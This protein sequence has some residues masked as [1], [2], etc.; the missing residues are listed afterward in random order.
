MAETAP[1][2]AIRN[3]LQR[4]AARLKALASLRDAAVRYEQKLGRGPRSLDDLV[5]S[6]MLAAIPVDPFGAGF[7]IGPDGQPAVRTRK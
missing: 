5:S 4:R 3:Y 6:G 2:G 7:V 1:A